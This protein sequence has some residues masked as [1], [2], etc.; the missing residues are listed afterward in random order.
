MSRFLRIH[1]ILC[2]LE[3]NH[4]TDTPAFSSFLS[5]ALRTQQAR[6]PGGLAESVRKAANDAIDSDL[7]TYMSC[8]YR[9]LLVE[10]FVVPGGICM[11]SFMDR[12]V[13]SVYAFVC[14]FISNILSNNCLDRLSFRNPSVCGALAIS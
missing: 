7:Y 2:S 9:T 5:R 6:P 1:D 4:L 11:Q 14:P 12:A 8:F 3:S 10:N 13:A